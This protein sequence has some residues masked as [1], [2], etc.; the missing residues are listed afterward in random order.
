MVVSAMLVKERIELSKINKVIRTRLMEFY[1]E[2]ALISKRQGAIT[3]RI[4]DLYRQM[5]E[6][7]V[8]ALLFFII[9]GTIFNASLGLKKNIR[10]FAV[11]THTPG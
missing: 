6:C 9:N 4:S 11:P 1:K 3:Q 8:V 10:I 5:R 2:N 7:W